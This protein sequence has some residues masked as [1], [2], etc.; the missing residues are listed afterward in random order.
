MYAETHGMTVAALR[1]LQQ[2]E[3][4]EI[5]EQHG[6]QL[7]CADVVTWAKNPKSAL[8]CAFEWNDKKAGDE[9]RLWQARQLIRTVFVE[10]T[11]P[12]QVTVEVRGWVSLVT[13]RKEPEG[14]YRLLTAVLEVPEQRE[15]LLEQARVEL[16]ALR[17]KY[18][19]L[20][21]LAGVWAEVDKQQ[22]KKK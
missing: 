20:T 4:L 5:H 19:Q 7:K 15:E 17:R 13:D 10:I 8:H 2:A 11:S 3:L 1:E 18:A 12:S 21:E 6:G 9:Y 16:A 22:P 14:G